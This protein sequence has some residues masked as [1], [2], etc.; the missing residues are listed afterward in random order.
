MERHFEVNHPTIYRLGDY[1]SEVHLQLVGLLGI[2]VEVKEKRIW[3]CPFEDGHS[4]PVA[5]PEM[6]VALL[7]SL[8][9]ADANDVDISV[10]R[11][12]MLKVESMF[13]PGASLQDSTTVDVLLDCIVEARRP[14]RLEIRGDIRILPSPNFTVGELLIHI[15]L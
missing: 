12:L 2:A 13:G 14:Q 3:T 8:H 7:H 1:Y 5:I 6:G 11:R 15:P 4:L 10:N 9:Y